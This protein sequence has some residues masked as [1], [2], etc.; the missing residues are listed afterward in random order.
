MFQIPEF[1]DDQLEE[2]RDEQG[3][4]DAEY[5]RLKLEMA[6]LVLAYDQVRAK[7]RYLYTI[8]GWPLRSTNE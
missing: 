4:V 5:A 6:P 2:L 7:K 8:L 3:R 1:T